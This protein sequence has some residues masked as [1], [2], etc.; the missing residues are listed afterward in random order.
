MKLLFAEFLGTKKEFEKY[1]SQYPMI[2]KWLKKQGVKC[3]NTT[4]L[5][6]PTKASAKK[7]AV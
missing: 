2:Y 6:S 5:S 1:V 7:K 4:R 3:E